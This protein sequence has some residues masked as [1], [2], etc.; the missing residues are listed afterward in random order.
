MTTLCDDRPFLATMAV[1]P[2]LPTRCRYSIADARCFVT[3]P[4][5]VGPASGHGGTD[6]VRWGPILA[7]E[8]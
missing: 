4:E 1:P 7:R 2:L 6:G 3:C 5:E 8:Q